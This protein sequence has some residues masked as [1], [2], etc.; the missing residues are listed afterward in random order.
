MQDFDIDD[1]HFR[2]VTSGGREAGLSEG[3][4]F[5]L[6]KSAAHMRFYEELR[7]LEPRTVMEIGMGQGG[8]M[9]LWDKWFRPE[10]LVGLDIIREPLEALEQYRADKPHI[11][12]YY[13][14]RQETG[15]TLGRARENFPNGID[16]VI[17]DASHHYEPSRITFQNIF[18]LV[19]PGG[20]Y[21]IEDW[22][23]AHS[24]AYQDPAHPW[25][26]APALTN[27]VF[28]LVVAVAALG[29]VESM[30]VEPGLVAVKR[31][32]GTLAPGAL[33]FAGALRGKALPKI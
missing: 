23:W 17:E 21:I 3:N 10:R 4:S 28:E 9:V 30:R 33:D 24:R 20:W 27:L 25:A 19:R 32:P 12:T 15:A 31:G 2:I 11:R 14:H 6:C 5:T 13:S 16:L 8:S 29:A 26:D 7:A 18:P 22:S 1:I